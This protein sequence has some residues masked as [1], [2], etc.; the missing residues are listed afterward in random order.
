MN[1]NK[2]RILV[3]DDE[4]SFTRL[5]KLNLERTGQYEVRA[6]NRSTERFRRLGI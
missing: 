6:E 2:N 3:V 1:T 5:L 4:P